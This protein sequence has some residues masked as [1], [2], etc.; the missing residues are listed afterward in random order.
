MSF[1]IKAASAAFGAV[2][3]AVGAF[4]SNEKRAVQKIQQNQAKKVPTVYA[5]PRPSA[6]QQKL[7]RYGVVA[8]L[9]PGQFNTDIHKKTAYFATAKKALEVAEA[10]DGTVVISKKGDCETVQ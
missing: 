6:V 10:T 5:D 4:A 9:T 8:H 2:V 1:A 3:G 7:Q